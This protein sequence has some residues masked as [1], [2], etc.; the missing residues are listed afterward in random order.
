MKV[1]FN[2]DKY[3]RRNGQQIISIYF[4]IQ[5]NKGKNKCSNQIQKGDISQYSQLYLIIRRNKQYDNKRRLYSK[6]YIK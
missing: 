2:G 1:I 6:Y 4:L 5:S 3:L